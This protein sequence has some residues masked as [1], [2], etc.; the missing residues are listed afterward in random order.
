MPLNRIFTFS[1]TTNSARAK[2]Q[3]YGIPMIL[4]YS[5]AWTERSR[6][7]GR[8][9][10]VATDFAITT[11]EYKAATKMFSNK[12]RPRSVVI[13][14]GA[15]K[16]TQK[17]TITPKVATNGAVYSVRV[18]GTTHSI[19]ADGSTS[20]TEI[21]DALRTPINAATDNTVTGT[22]TSTLI[23]TGD[24]AGGWNAVEVMTPLLLSIVQDHADPGVATDLDAILAENQAWYGIHNAFNSKAMIDAIG[25]WTD[26][27]SK[28]FAAQTQDSLVADNALSGTDD[29]GESTKANSLGRTHVWYSPGTDDFVDAGVLGKCLPLDPGSETWAFKN[30]VGVTAKPLSTTQITNLV[31]KN[32]NWY[33][34]ISDL[35][36]TQGGKMANGEWIDF[37]RGMDWLEANMG[38]GVLTA[39]YNADKIPY[40][41]GGAQSIGGI[42]EA[43]LAR[44]V[45]AGLLRD[46]PDP[47]VIV[48]DVADMSEEDRSARE[49][50]PIEFTAQAAGAIHTTAVQ[51]TVSV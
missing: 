11:P 34:E 10:E 45:K 17:W 6:T 41:N 12:K 13:G 18:N 4:S 48:P 32:V 39:K 23:L 28:F 36:F 33:E 21:C 1:I 47:E 14:R 2:A 37:V 19:T 51:G 49:Y 30:L 25:S 9:S 50:G 8:L 35:S 43:W 27:N 7:Y 29:V 20:A 38:A 31:A 5:A 3:G 44:G 26:T 42:V 16:P 15:L 22:G 40:T 24:A 46:D